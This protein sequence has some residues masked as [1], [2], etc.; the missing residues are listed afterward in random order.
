MSEKKEMFV[1][2][3]EEEKRVQES[4]RL[5]TGKKDFSLAAW[6]K[7]A[8]EQKQIVKNLRE[9]RDLKLG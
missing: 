5:K 8:E 6:N 3:T 2:L 4:I 7:H 9:N 1:E